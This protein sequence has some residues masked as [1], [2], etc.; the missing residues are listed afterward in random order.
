MSSF[1]FYLS[2]TFFL[3]TCVV[4]ILLIMIQTG[5]GGGL[6]SALGGSSGSAAFG[7][8]TGVALL[9]TTGASFFAL[10]GLAIALSRLVN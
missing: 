3:I 2:L 5:R 9:C 8:K 7:T 6:S 10:I 4:L 1:L